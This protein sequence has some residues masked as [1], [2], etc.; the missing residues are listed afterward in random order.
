MPEDNTKASMPV[1]GPALITV[2]QRING[3][4]VESQLTD[5][6]SHVFHKAQFVDDLPFDG[7]LVTIAG[8]QPRLCAWSKA[9]PDWTCEV[10]WNPK[11]GG[12][13]DRLRDF[14]IGDVHGNGKD[15]I[16]I[17]THDQGVVAVLSRIGEQWNAQE[18]D[19]APRTFVHEIELGDTDGDGQLE[20]FATP[21]QPNQAT[22]AS[23]PG[24]IV[25]YQFEGTKVFKRTIAD[26][27]TTHC[28]EI[29][30][31][32]VDQDGKDELVAAIE[33]RTEI[34][35]GK[36]EVVEPIQIVL[37]R[38]V[39]GEFAAETLATIP[40]Q[41]CRVL[42]KGDIDGDGRTDIIATA[43]KS[44]IW[45][46]QQAD[47]GKWE[48]KLIDRNSS[49]IEHAATLHDFDGK[50]RDSIFV[51]SEREGELRKYSYDGSKFLK[52]TITKTPKN[53]IT[54]CITSSW[55]KPLN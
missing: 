14:E 25:Q 55:T 31:V 44:G 46:L 12:R 20:I 27:K 15:A 49:G 38:A 3:T 23:Q 29:L 32:D 10:L 43:M 45:W 52:T 19:R 30:A 39:E 9:G 40:D 41:M 33:A 35:G 1:P 13:Q 5:A 53:A 2:L 51:V 16:A 34:L 11:F 8:S 54:F 28:K 24:R 17:G 37:F 36:T 47:G 7:R 26:L 6:H 21:S 4:W 42:C 18:I 22:L 50:G 48:R